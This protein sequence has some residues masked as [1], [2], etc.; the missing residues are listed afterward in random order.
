MAELCFQPA[1]LARPA[2]E[3]CAQPPDMSFADREV[4]AAL[5][6]GL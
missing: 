6:K 2:M 4:F 1:S 3:T 5:E